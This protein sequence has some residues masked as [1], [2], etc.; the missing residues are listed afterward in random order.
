MMYR[1]F[2]GRRISGNLQFRRGG[3]FNGHRTSFGISPEFRTSQNLSLEP[4]YEWNRIS[5]PGST[6]TTQEFNGNVNYSFNQ[7]WLTRTTLLLDSQGKEYTF[8]FRLN[9][10]YRSGDDVFVVYTET[11]GYGDVAGLDNRALIVKS[12]FSFDY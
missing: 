9:Y 7:R 11:R 2:R 3:F 8:N 5:L 4:G 12:S 6:F 1:A 10:I